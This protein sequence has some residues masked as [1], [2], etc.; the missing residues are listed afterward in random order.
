MNAKARE[1]GMTSAHFVE[2]TGLSDEN[3]ASP[4]DLSKLVDGGGP[5]A[6]HPRVLHRQRLRRTV[7]RRLVQFH[8]TDSLVNKP[9]WNIVVQK[10]G[11]IYEAGR[12]LVMQTVIEERTVIIVLLN[13]FG[14]RTRVADATAFASGWKQ[15]WRRRRP[16]SDHLN[17]PPAAPATALPAALSCTRAP[18][19]ARLDAPEVARGRDPGAEPAERRAR[20][21]AGRRCRRV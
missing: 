5:G 4:E 12:C 18:S 16:A 13:S 14:K 19:G 2:P 3:V 10:T 17:R 15:P 6:Y 9:D 21:P 7:G 1:L 11:Y 20:R 8:N